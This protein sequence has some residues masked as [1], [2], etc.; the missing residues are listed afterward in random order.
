[1]PLCR[2]RLIDRDNDRLVFRTIVRQHDVPRTPT[3]VPQQQSARI[4]SIVGVRIDDIILFDHGA[5]PG[6]RDPTQEHAAQSMD[7]EN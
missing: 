1:M 3:R 2:I 6:K 5:Y 4:G 7:T